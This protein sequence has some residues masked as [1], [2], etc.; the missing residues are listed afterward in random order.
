VK[1]LEKM[2]SSFDCGV[3]YFGSRY[4]GL[5]SDFVQHIYTRLKGFLVSFSMMYMIFLS[6]LQFSDYRRKYRKK[7][8]KKYKILTLVEPISEANKLFKTA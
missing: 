7:C 8:E 3:V 4:L 6:V 2:L 1:T 5:F